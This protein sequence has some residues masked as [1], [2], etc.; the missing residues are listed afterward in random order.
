MSIIYIAYR[1]CK[2][3]HPQM[4]YLSCHKQRYRYIQ[5]T[6]G[7]KKVKNTCFLTMYILLRVNN[8]RGTVSN[9]QQGCVKWVHRV[10][11]VIDGFLCSRQMC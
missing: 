8:N 1:L 5:Y 2:S 4:Q 6:K 3:V 10:N 11:P 9:F 7:W